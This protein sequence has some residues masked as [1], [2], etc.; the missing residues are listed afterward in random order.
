VGGVNRSDLIRVLQRA[1]HTD[2]RQTVDLITGTIAAALHDGQPVM[3][4]GFGVFEPR[5]HGERLVVNPFVDSVVYVPPRVG[6]GFRPSRSLLAKV[7]DKPPEK[8][9]DIGF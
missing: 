6:V 8:P 9:T 2:A 4:M 7:N 5:P 1:G 3:L